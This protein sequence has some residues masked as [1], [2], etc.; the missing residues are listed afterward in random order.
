MDGDDVAHP[1][2]LRRQVDALDR[3][4]EACLVGS[5]FE[6]IDE[7][8]RRVRPRDRS[9][10]AAP[11]LFAPFP[12][13]SI[14]FRR[15]AFEAAGGYRTAADFWEDLDLYR[16]MGSLGDL[17]VLPSA[18]YRH[19]SSPLSTR[20]T[21]SRPVVESAIDRMYR[22]A[23]GEGPRPRG[24]RGL[25]PEVWLSLGSTLLWAGRRPGR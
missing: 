9:R 22:R 21:S 14:M 4:P 11:T 8:G 10:L 24:V 2:R 20:L 6:G 23:A 16:R 15:E 13:G 17:I 25:K 1:D 18:L 7:Q 12:H 5:L 3:H 19:R